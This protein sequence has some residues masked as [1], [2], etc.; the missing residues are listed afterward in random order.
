MSTSFIKKLVVGA[1]ILC[2]I[3]LSFAQRLESFSTDS[4]VFIDEFISKLEYGGQLDKQQI[5]NLRT[6]WVSGSFSVEEKAH[7]IRDVNV[8]VDKKY[9]IASNITRYTELALMLKEGGNYVEL[10]YKDLQKIM[11]ESLSSLPNKDLMVFL[12]R[13]IDYLPSGKLRELQRFYWKVFDKAPVLGMR[14]G[15]TDT[16]SLNMPMLIFEGVDLQYVSLDDSMILYNTSG[17]FNILT[18]T[19]HGEGGRVDWKKVGLP[20]SD[21][22]A[23]MQSYQLD[24]N[25]G[26]FEADS[27]KFFYNSLLKEPVYG[28]FSDRNI[29][30]GDTAKAQYPHFESY[31]RDVVIENWIPNVRY[32]GGFTL[33]GTKIKGSAYDG[34]GKFSSGNAEIPT[35]LVG[36]DSALLEEGVS[37]A[38][39]DIKRSDRYVLKMI[40]KDFELSPAEVLGFSAATTIYTTDGDSITHPGLDLSYSVDDRLIVLKKPSRG[41]FSHRPYMSSYHDFYLYFETL[42]W[43]VETDSIRFTS[44]LDKENKL[45][46]IESFDYFT[47]SRFNQAKHVLRFNPVG[48]IYRYALKYEG[49]TIT[50][51]SIIKSFDAR[52]DMDNQLEAFEQSLPSLESAGY[53][54][55]DRETGIIKPQP[56]LFKW[57]MAARG[58]KDYDAI[59]II[60]QVDTGDHAYISLNSQEL[61]MRGVPYFAFSDSQYVVVNPLYKEVY[62]SKDRN[63]RFGGNIAAGKVN[64]YAHKAENFE[65]EY[66]TFK[67]LCDSVDAIKFQLVRNPPPDYQY[68]PLEQALSN[69]VFENVSGAIHIDGPKNK[70][71]KK[72]LGH[73]PV[74]DSYQNSY[75]YWDRQEIQGGVY[76]RDSLYFAVFPFVLDSLDTFQEQGLLFAGEFYSSEIFPLITDTLT[77]MPDF[78]LGFRV[79]TPE[80]GYDVYDYRGKYYSDIILDGSGLHGKGRLEHGGLFVNSDSIV[81]HFDSVMAIVDSFQMEQGYHSGSYFPS[82]EGTMSY[83]VW[84]PKTD[85]VVFNTLEMDADSVE[86][87]GISVFDGEAEFYGQLKISQDGLVGNGKLRLSEVEVDGENIAIKERDFEAIDATFTIIDTLNPK[88]TYYQ[89]QGVNVKYDI[90]RHESSFGPLDNDVPLASFDQQ[91]Y[92]TSLVLG[93]YNREA[94]ELRLEGGSDNSSDNFFRWMDDTGDTLEFFAQKALYKIDE[95]KIDVSGVPSIVVADALITPKDLGLTVREDGLI[96]SLKDATI[97]ASVISRDHKIY[98]ADVAIQSANSYTGSG[99]YDY[100]EVDEKRQFI[101]FEN[102]EVI[103]QES[104]NPTTYAIGKVGGEDPFYLTDRIIFEGSAELNAQNRFLRFDGEVK[105]ESDNPIFEGEWFPFNRTTVNPDSVFIPI[106]SYM[107]NDEGDEVISGLMYVPTLREFYSSF[108]QPKIDPEDPELLLSSGGLTVDRSTQAFRIGPED[109]IRN[110]TYRGSTVT[111]DDQRNIITSKGYID[112]PFNFSNKT[113]EMEMVGSWE[114]NIGDASINTDLLVGVNFSILPEE[115][116]GELV[117]NFNLFSVNKPDIDFLERSL[118][119]NISELLDKG[120]RDDKETKNFIEEVHDAMVYTDINLAS[121]LPFTLLMSN[122]D[123]DYDPETGSLYSNGPIGI[124]GVGGKPVN[125]MI[126]AKILYQIGDDP[127]FK[128]RELDKLTIYLEVDEYNWV[129]FDFEGEVVRTVAPYDN[130]NVPIL[131]ESEEQKESGDF[132]FELASIEEAQNFKRRIDQKSQ[133]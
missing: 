50:P 9:G 27:T 119:E 58:K 115:P 63:L 108:L 117:S 120:K 65:F 55:Y 111:F 68:T 48:A 80:E 83:Y 12:E 41:P 60:S 62:V 47:E 92:K 24:V 72:S 45:S 88:I 35:D 22:Y 99:K 52:Y 74:F 3:S 100:I 114:E 61:V 126:K 123:F 110:R 39:V 132:R 10:T 101:N 85:Q 107:T 32:Q 21:V 15:K 42:I 82:L 97:E 125:K 124:I 81:F 84:Y 127:P 86:P 113:A 112:F 6:L 5:T 33:S 76:H 104:G 25:N 77:V 56:K 69:T 129:Y 16:D 2:T 34:N 31:T 71:G 109:K 96:D 131:E 57:T 87:P 73:F 75:V 49:E 19:F 26:L 102:I 66:E 67:I 4:E 44:L 89:A 106:D 94:R 18:R 122:V 8:M 43:D 54:K 118:L 79:E 78:T 130:Y 17:Y 36:A 1:S 7:F 38:R 20:A 95:K 14:V 53:I 70:S 133:E 91:G 13:M 116:L 51:E 93:E 29:G 37:G 103:N 105:I 98:E 40:G 11:E 23:E 30:V 64:F 46:A 128:E 121:R 59:Q 28:Y 90:D